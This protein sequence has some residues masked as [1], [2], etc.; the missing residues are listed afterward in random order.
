MNQDRFD[1]E[2]QALL[3]AYAMGTLTESER[4]RLFEKAIGN[5]LIF[6]A[7]MDEEAMRATLESPHAKRALANALEKMDG[8]RGPLHVYAGA[9]APAPVAQPRVNYFLWAAVACSLVVSA[10]TAAW[11]VRT[12]EVAA[13]ALVA[14]AQ[15]EPTLVPAPE[16]TP[17]RRTEPERAAGPVPRPAPAADTTPVTSPA[18]APAPSAKE[19]EVRA[20]VIVGEARMDRK[21][22]DATADAL[23]AASSAQANS[24]REAA[25][26]EGARSAKA[27][28]DA[29]VASI[30]NKQLILQPTADGFAYAFVVAGDSI[31]ALWAPAAA[32]VKA[33]ERR[34]TTV[35]TPGP[36][37][38]LWLLITEMPDPVL[39]RALSGVLPLPSRNWSKIPIP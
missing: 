30:L 35:E 17:I 28:Q 26:A 27:R 29:P 6:D 34:A 14:V 13:P 36:K 25:P 16:P 15:R 23:A 24:F 18:P 20:P 21:T 33:G 7:L 32:A 10:V 8:E 5:Q 22:F 1:D 39:N 19:A 31:K 12:S 2:M 38:E 9:M 11:L 37:A 3:S 4:A